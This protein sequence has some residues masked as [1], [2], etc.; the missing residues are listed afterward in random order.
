[1][2]TRL[3]LLGTVLA[4]TILF[5]PVM[6]S[7]V[8]AQDNVTIEFMQWWQPE[9]EEGV[10]EALIEDYEES[11]PNV[12]VKLLSMPFDEV[13]SQLLV[14]AKA[15]NL[16][17][18]F[19]VHPPYLATY[20]E[21][22]MLVPI[23]DYVENSDFNVDNVRAAG[24][25]EVNGKHWTLPVTT[26]IYP[27]FYNK[28]LMEEAGFTSPPETLLEFK[29]YAKAINELGPN[30][31]GVGFGFSTS[32]PADA[33]STDVMDWVYARNGHI[34]K[35]GELNLT[36]QPFLDTLIF[37]Q[38]LNEMGVVSPGS[39][40]KQHSKA[41]E[42]FAAGRLG[43][44]LSSTAHI[45][46]VKNRNPDLDFNVA[47]V[48]VPMDYS[49]QGGTRVARWDVGVSRDAEDKEEAA[50]FAMWL[51]TKGP[52]TKV[53]MASNSFPSNAAAKPDLSGKPIAEKAFEIKQTVRLEE[54]FIGKSKVTDMQR[55]FLRKLPQLWNGK[56]A[57]EE[58]ASSVQD[59]WKEILSE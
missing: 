14:Q 22:D 35:D 12:N 19:G 41:M 28:S 45:Q 50:E 2:N 56:I 9:M 25:E 40:A 53:A 57:P 54:D 32:A 5:V 13:R 47:K 37:L 42:E 59:E 46:I 43:F 52:N 7:S 51:A 48:P 20:L 38:K 8:A 36:S 23:E 1:M 24:Y 6:S 49:G 15:R 26:F 34:F 21:N 29:T 33:F 18:V 16:P 55:A 58:L 4:V 39:L 3:R 27:L 30:K 10:F 11:H 44:L 31:Y 17:D